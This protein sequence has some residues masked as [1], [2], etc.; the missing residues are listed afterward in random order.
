MIQRESSIITITTEVPTEIIETTT[1]KIT[2]IIM[3]YAYYVGKDQTMPNSEQMPKMF[4][5]KILLPHDGTT[6]SEIFKHYA[7]THL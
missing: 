1:D 5:L 6:N 4:L 3:D 2:I 7:A